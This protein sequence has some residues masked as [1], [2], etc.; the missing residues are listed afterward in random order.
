MFIHLHVASGF[1]MPNVVCFLKIKWEFHNLF[2]ELRN[3]RHVCTYLITFSMV[4]PNIVLKFKNF[5]NFDNIF[6][7]L[8]PVFCSRLPPVVSG[9]HLVSSDDLT[10]VMSERAFRDGR[11][12]EGVVCGGVKSWFWPTVY[13]LTHII[14]HSFTWLVIVTGY[15][16]K[17]MRGDGNVVK[18]GRRYGIKRKAAIILQCKSNVKLNSCLDLY[19]VKSYY[20]RRQPQCL[21]TNS[22]FY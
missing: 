19:C 18:I 12:M 5:D 21:T 15:S 9:N 8:W 14:R 17:Y 20:L 7:N 4:N 11:C 6:L 16:I 1:N 13:V 10:T 22:T 3:T 2:H